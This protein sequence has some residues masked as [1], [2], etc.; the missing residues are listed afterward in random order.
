MSAKSTRL[1]KEARSVF[2][3]WLAVISAATVPLLERSWSAGSGAVP[4][5]GIYQGIEPASFLGFFIGLPLL[6]TLSLGNEFQCRTVALLLSQPVSRTEIWS[7]KLIVAL[8]AVLSAASLFCITGRKV[9]QQDPAIGMISAALMIPMVASAP[10]WTLL[11]R[12]TLGGLALNALNAAI[13]VVW[14]NRRDWIPQSALSRSVT[15]FAVVCYSGVMLWLGRRSLARFE[16]TG[17]PASDDLLMAGPNVL[18]GAV[19]E[20]FRCRPTGLLVN[21]VRKEFRLLRP[22]WLISLLAIPIWICL[23]LFGHTS[24]KSIPAFILVVAFIPLVAVLAGSLSLG[25]ERTSG[26]HSL[27]LTLPASSR[28]QWLI[29]LALAMFT[30]LVCAAL[31]PILAL[32]VSKMFFGVAL[33]PVDSGHWISWLLPVSLLTFA[34]F[35]CACTVNGTVRA[36]LCVFPVLIAIYL[37]GGFGDW[38]ANLLFA[39]GRLQ[40]VFSSLG[41]FANFRFTN[42][43][44]NLNLFV[45]AALPYLFFALWVVPTLLFA[46]T[47]SSRLF[48][49]QLQESKLFVLRRLCLWPSS[50]SYAPFHWLP[51]MHSYST[52]NDRCGPCSRKPTM[53]LTSSK[54]VSQ[55]WMPSILCN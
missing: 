26:T 27:H 28:R 49:K 20:W 54:L 17:G 22:V 40:F 37:A 14:L 44:S 43:V 34:S 10:F 53:R 47:Q 6:A 45:D 42:A 52:P 5:W 38:A 46:V 16:V 33:L 15:L 12:S 19:S 24:D 25:E 18:R 29:K 32:I 2:W 4:L 39:A 41:L 7:E 55:T 30:S 51:S 48:R 23:P 3:P 50:H 36:A 31:L 11:A 9:I 1:V 13:P 21:L 8:A 35:W